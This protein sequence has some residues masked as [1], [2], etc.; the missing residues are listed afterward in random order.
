MSCEMMTSSYLSVSPSLG[1]FVPD[2]T[3][4]SGPTGGGM[5][6]FGFDVCW[7][8]DFCRLECGF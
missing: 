8:A 7:S 6:D 3:E 1:I 4:S 2:M 5:P